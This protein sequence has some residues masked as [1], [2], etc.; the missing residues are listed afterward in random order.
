MRDILGSIRMEIF[1]ASISLQSITAV[2][3]KLPLQLGGGSG[4]RCVLT[5]A[6]IVIFK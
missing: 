3:E 5:L 4:P 2:R 1:F 6:E